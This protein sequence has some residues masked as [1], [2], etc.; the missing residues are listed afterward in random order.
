MMTDIQKISG[1]KYE[2][3]LQGND[4]VGLSTMEGLLI[5]KGGGVAVKLS[6]L[7]SNRKKA[8]Q[9]DKFSILLYEGAGI[10]EQ[11]TGTW[12][13]HGYETQP[14]YSGTWRMSIIDLP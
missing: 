6:K 12:H 9:K 10:P 5:F 11:L 8:G 3:K 7:Y 2:I 14:K 1:S 13:F 4:S